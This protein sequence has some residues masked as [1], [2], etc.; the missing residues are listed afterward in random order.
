LEA[1]HP[2]L[3]NTS[4]IDFLP[5][6]PLEEVIARHTVGL[7]DPLQDESI[8]AKDKLNDGLPQSLAA[9]LRTYGL[10]HFKIKVTG[11]LDHDLDRLEQIARILEA[12]AASDYK[13]TLD[14]N[15]QFH[16]LAHFRTYWQ[17][18]ADHAKL[19][20]FL[21]HLLF[22]EQPL[23]RDVALQPDV[24]Q[25]FADWV[26]RPS[27][28]IDESDGTLGS[29]ANALKLGYAGTSHKNCKGIFKGISNRCLLANVQKEQPAGRLLM[30]GEDLCTIGPVSVIQDLAVM[31]AL[32][33]SSVERN[34]HHYFAGLS[35]WPKEIQQQ[36]LDRHG[37]L[38]RSTKL[39]WPALNVQ[40]GRLDVRAL[41]QHPFGV[42]FAVDVEQ[43]VESEKYQPK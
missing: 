41:H 7:A 4:P 20:E 24:G 11:H 36:T 19:A 10:C 17:T 27:I 6:R 33:I 23:H 22:V 32:G 43:F 34:G 15:E 16:S 42:G 2:S 40:N 13:F 5:K 14:G 1:I 29:V 31:S 21:K 28:I 12:G 26:N 18:V 39:D 35:M 38:Y 25:L 30:S 8:A 37:H 9:C 3:R